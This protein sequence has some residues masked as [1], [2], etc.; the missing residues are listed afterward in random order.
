MMETAQPDPMKA[1][2]EIVEPAIEALRYWN[3]HGP[4][5]IEDQKLSPNN[6][7]EFK[8]L[9]R[10]LATARIASDEI[11]RHGVTIETAT[12]GRKSNPAVAALVSAQAAARQ[13]LTRFDL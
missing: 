1:I 12:G 5:L 9:C 13:L 8:M 6:A 2:R 3:L 7:E 4:G 11:E 10:L